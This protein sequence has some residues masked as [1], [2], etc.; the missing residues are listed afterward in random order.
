[1][2]CIHQ[3]WVYIIYK[4]GPDLYIADWL[5][6]NNH[7]EGKDQ[8]ITGININMN[9]ISTTG[10]N[11]GCTSIEDMQASTHEDAHLQKLK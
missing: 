1:M 10:N 4:P 7:T 11:P 8:E 3:Y 2:L 9:A 6:R 5:S